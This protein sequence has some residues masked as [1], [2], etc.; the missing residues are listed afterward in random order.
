MLFSSCNNVAFCVVW[1]MLG[2]VSFAGFVD[3]VVV[4]VYMVLVA[5]EVSAGVMALELES[6]AAMVE[7]QRCLLL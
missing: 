5:V 4:R 2:F 7:G 3:F 1:R 6:D